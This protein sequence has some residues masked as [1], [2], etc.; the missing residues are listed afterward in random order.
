MQTNCN[1]TQA[2][3]KFF[4][5]C[6]PHNPDKRSNLAGRICVDR[7]AKLPF[8][9][10]SIASA[11][12]AAFSTANSAAD[13]HTATFYRTS[14]AAD[15]HTAAFHSTSSVADAHTNCYKHTQCSSSYALR[16]ILHSTF[17]IQH[18]RRHS[19]RVHTSHITHH[20]SHSKLRSARARRYYSKY[21]PQNPTFP[22]HVFFACGGFFCA[23][24]VYTHGGGRVL[25][26]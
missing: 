16:A 22:Q 11:H 9:A 5:S 12:T 7:S 26:H 24:S 18:S 1:N 10:N 14:S 6:T 8:A 13:A 4:K 20:T 25:F 17:C 21:F 3:T 2:G 15:A 19:R 23:I